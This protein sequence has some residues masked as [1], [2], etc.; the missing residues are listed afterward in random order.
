MSAADDD[1][2]FGCVRLRPSAR[3]RHSDLNYALLLNVVPRAGRPEIGN[4]VAEIMPVLKLRST[5]ARREALAVVVANLFNAW[6]TIGAPFLGVPLRKSDYAPGTRLAALWLA[7]RPVSDVV[8]ALHAHGYVELHAG[9]HT[10]ELKRRTRIRALDKLTRLFLRHRLHLDCLKLADQAEVVL[11][12]EKLEDGT[13]RRID[14]SRGKL[15]ATAKPLQVGVRRINEALA[16]AKIELYVEED[17][18]IKHFIAKRIGKK[19]PINPPSPLHNRFRRVFNRTFDLGGRFYAHWCQGLPRE[20]RRHIL[21]NG[22]PIQELDFKALHPSLLYAEAGLPAPTEVY[23]P[24]GWPP[25]QRNIFKVLMLSTLNAKSEADAI[26]GTR[27]DL[28][29]KYHELLKRKE[30]EENILT[31]EWLQSAL[32]ALKDM[33]APIARHFCT[34]VGLRLQNVDSRIAERVMHELLDQG[35]VSL[36]EHDSFLVA[37]SHVEELRRAMFN[38]SVAVCGVPVAVDAKYVIQEQL[39][40]SDH[41]LTEEVSPVMD[42][43]L[44]ATLFAGFPHTPKALSGYSTIAAPQQVS[45]ACA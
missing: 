27:Y 19:N 22:E 40:L 6:A 16:S 29:T 17:V 28:F 32:S 11:H 3:R 25:E 1:M 34:G 5:K 30:D 14:I 4:T 33:H 31:S 7:Y 37:V 18:F 41:A 26:Q 9:L 13:R 44:R 2:V 20:L 10:P 36:C 21:I 35:I 43:G 39:S 42:E 38:A 45:G 24:E 12:A 8:R 15:A 23:L